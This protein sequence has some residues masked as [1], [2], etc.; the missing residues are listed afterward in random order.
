MSKLIT[1]LKLLAVFSLL[2]V[3]VWGATR[4]DGCKPDIIEPTQPDRPVVAVPKPPLFPR[5]HVIVVRP[6]SNRTVDRLPVNPRN[7][8]EVVAVDS[9]VIAVLKPRNRWFPDLKKETRIRVLE[10]DH[11]RVV[12]TL[13]PAPLFEFTPRFNVGANFTRNSIQ[14]SVGLELARLW[15][16]RTGVNVGYD[17]RLKRVDVGPEAGVQIRSN[18]MMNFGYHVNSQ[19]P[20][21][22]I[23]YRF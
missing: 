3:L 15:L 21:L 22:S 17:T 13:Q 4:L 23:K 18:L 5:D 12:T 7:I 19:Q 16:L 2:G 20:F 14:P 1:L 6:D 11:T 10:G 8:D 9:T